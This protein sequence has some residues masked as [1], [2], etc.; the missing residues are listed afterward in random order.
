MMS[1]IRIDRVVTRGGDTGTT[2]LADGSRVAKDDPR[3]EALG[4]IDEANASLGALASLLD[5]GF[6]AAVIVRVQ[7]DLFDLGAGL[8]RPG[9]DAHLAPDALDALEAATARLNENLAPLESFVLP[10]GAQAAAEAHRARTVVRRA[11]RRL[12]SLGA[13]TGVDAGAC[14]YVNRLSDFLFVLARHL[15]DDGRRD[16]AW[17]PA[18]RR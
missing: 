14:R 8:C 4:A 16:V 7:N 1:G 9:A 15:N 18:S 17:V 6:A 12:W 13:G 5:A 10:G 11:E 2:S 3:I